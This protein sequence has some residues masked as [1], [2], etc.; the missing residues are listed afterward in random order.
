MISDGQVRSIALFFFFTLMDEK[1][2]IQAAHKAVSHAKAF[3]AADPT[4][5]ETEASRISLIRVLKKTFD[6]HRRLVPKNQI[7]LQAVTAQETVLNLAVDATLTPWLKFQR[8]TGENEVVAV[9]LSRVLGFSDEEI[10]S[11]L[12]ISLGTARY[13]IGKGMRQLGTFAK[14]R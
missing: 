7:S 8:D 13:R 3:G 4:K 6:S 12:G 5:P 2:A 14:A 1:V 10:A 9:A 11:G